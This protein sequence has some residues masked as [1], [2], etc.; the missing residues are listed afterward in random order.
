MKCYRFSCRSHALLTIVMEESWIIGRIRIRVD[1][2]KLDLNTLRVHV[3]CFE[4]AEKNLRIQKY[5]YMC[6]RGLGNDDCHGNINATKQKCIDV[7]EL[8]CSVRTG[9]IL[10]EFQVSGSVQKLTDRTS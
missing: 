3:K 6:G 1:A 2:G 5:P 10:V 9:K 8:A 4:S 7:I